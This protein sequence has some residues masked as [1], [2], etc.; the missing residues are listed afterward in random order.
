MIEVFGGVIDFINSVFSGDWEGAW[1]AIKEIGVGIW[2]TISSLWEGFWDGL[3]SIFDGVIDNIKNGFQS[4]VDWLA[5]K[6]SWITDGLNKIKDAWNWLK[7]S[8]VGEFVGGVK[9]T[10]SNAL[11]SA[12]DFLFGNPDEPKPAT[13]ATSAR[14]GNRTNNVNQ[15]INIQ[16][17]FCG[18]DREMQQKG[19]D[20]MGKAAND[21][22]DEAAKGLATGR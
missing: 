4:F 2:N 17:T 3:F 9:D 12:G 21:T 5:D 13:V 11:D 20:M 18:S 8:P 14:G 1:E 6:F 15:N 19:A 7:D 16:N 22:F 10:V